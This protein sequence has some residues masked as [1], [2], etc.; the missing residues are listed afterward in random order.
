MA[1]SAPPPGGLLEQ[2]L[3]LRYYADLLWRGRALVAAAA[4]TG[5]ALGLLT[6]F[7]Q[8]PE[9]RA[10]AMLQIE[11]PTPLFMSVTDALVGGGS[12][13]QHADFYN[14]QFRILRSHAVG[15]K[16]VRSLESRGKPLPEGPDKPGALIAHV[17]VEPIPDS[18]LALVQVTHRDPKVAAEWAN[19]VAEVYIEQSLSTR[20]DAAKRAYEWL[21]ERLQAT[22]QNMRDAQARLLKSY[23]SQDLFVPEGSVSAVTSSIT[24]LNEDFIAAQARLIELEAAV[25]QLSEMRRRGQG[26]ESVPQVATDEQVAA[27]NGQLASLNLEL[28]RLREK[29]KEAHPEVQKVLVQ[30]AQVTRSRD[31]RTAQI[32]QALRAEQAQLHKRAAELR[33]AIDEQKAQAATQSQKG[34]ELEAIKKEADSAKSLYEVLLQKLNETDIAASIRSN[35]VSLVERAAPPEDPVRPN[36]RRIAL[37]GLALGLLGGIGLLAGREYLDNTLKD[38]DEVERYL[39][40]DLLAAVPRHEAAGQHLVTEAYQNLRTALLFARK[41]DLG[42]VVLVTGT[43]P[44]EGKTTTLVNLARLMASSGERVVALDFDLRRAQ[45]HTRLGLARE[46]GLTDVFVR[47][48]EVGA[49]TRPTSVPNLSV[50][51]AGPLPPNPPALLARKNL[52]DV[53]DQLRQGFDWILLDSPPM[54]SV[55]DALLLARHV[56]IV[57]VVVQHNKVDKRL[58]K[59]SIVNLRRVTPNVLGVVLNVVDVKSKGYYYYYYQQQDREGGRAKVA[60][61]GAGKGSAQSSG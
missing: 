22:Q 4:L 30:V 7:L 17:T 21:Q 20:I 43:A 8:T 57:V 38:P 13:W 2:G 58:V 25:K 29:Y 42:Q 14:T 56:D 61:A 46:P 49:V 33:A 52:A 12:Y 41:D 53:F 45:L 28:T 40:T 37:L 50:I 18:R 36:K 32:E 15:E 26:V 55:T 10:S 5:A 34:S 3:D 9:Y 35:N 60:A 27:L 23:Q 19:A 44:Q 47:H 51:T 39:H 59:R 31:A 11:P 6:G 54:A 1:T 24:K 48:Q 16:A